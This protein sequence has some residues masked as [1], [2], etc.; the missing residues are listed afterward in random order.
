MVAKQ[1]R[2][3]IVCP[4][5]QGMGQVYKLKK[6]GTPYTILGNPQIIECEYCNGEKV[7][8]EQITTEHFFISSNIIEE[9]KKGFFN[10]W[11]RK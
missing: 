2:R 9:E 11:K 6:D 3:M 7:V 8:L 4:K 5:C 1:E 10:R